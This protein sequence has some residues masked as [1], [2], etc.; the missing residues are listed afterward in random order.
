MITHRA[1]WVFS[2]PGVSKT[3]THL[4]AGSGGFAPIAAFFQLD[5]SSWTAPHSPPLA[6]SRGQDQPPQDRHDSQLTYLVVSEFMCDVSRPRTAELGE[7]SP[8]T[9][10]DVTQVCPNQYLDEIRLR[11]LPEV[12][13]TM[14]REGCRYIRRDSPIDRS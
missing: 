2:R 12:C 14:R 8:D 13:V 7:R 10:T 3:R 1:G 5:S 11:A 4:N 9:Y 6:L